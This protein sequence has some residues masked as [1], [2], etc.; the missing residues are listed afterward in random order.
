MHTTTLDHVPFSIFIG[1]W[2]GFSKTYDVAGNFLESTA[3]HMDIA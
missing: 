3:V 1:K 2:E